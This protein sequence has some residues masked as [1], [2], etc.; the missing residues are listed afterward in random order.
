MV[1]ALVPGPGRANRSTSSRSAS[2]RRHCSSRWATRST[3]ASFARSSAPPGNTSAL[4]RPIRPRSRSSIETVYGGA[5]A[6]GAAP[7]RR[8]DSL[9][10][11]RRGAPTRARRHRRARPRRSQRRRHDRGRARR[12]HHS[13][14]RHARRDGHPHRAARG[15]RPDS[16]SRRRNAPERASL[17]EGAPAV[18]AEPHQNSR[19]S[20]HRREPSAAGRTRSHSRRRTPHRPSRLDVPD[21]PRRRH[22]AP[23]PRPQ[24][25]QPQARG[26]RHQRAGLSRCSAPRSTNRSACCRSPARPARER[27]RPS[28]RRC[29]SSTR[30]T[31]A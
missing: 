9:A 21:R 8:A 22:R 12:R 24:P 3:S 5:A 19:K 13:S 4:P 18:A 17:P 27:R 6:R 26:A 30:A 2:R 16:L 31:S 15:H 28:T 11:G 7:R 10:H 23:R 20:R 1:V 25:R 29:S 14:R